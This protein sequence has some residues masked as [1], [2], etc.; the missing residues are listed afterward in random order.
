MAMK[1]EQ[2]IYHVMP[3]GARWK[4]ISEAAPATFHSTE[5]EAVTTA[6]RCAATNESSHLIIHKIDGSIEEEH[7][8]RLGSFSATITDT[9]ERGRAQEPA[10]GTRDRSAGENRSRHDD[11]LRQNGASL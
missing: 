10:S 7:R 9:R 5:A 1:N 2:T 11:R 6:R 4:V 8:M 3:A